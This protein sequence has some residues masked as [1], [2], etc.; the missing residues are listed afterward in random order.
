M[1]KNNLNEIII[2]T[3]SKRSA[4]EII[5]KTKYNNRIN[6]FQNEKIRYRQKDSKLKNRT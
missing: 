1:K 4:N 6:E 2:S 3:Q 5:E